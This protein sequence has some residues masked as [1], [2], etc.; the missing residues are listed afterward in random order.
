MLKIN[1]EPEWL[2]SI[3]QTALNSL[4]VNNDRVL[5]GSD[6]ILTAP[7]W[8]KISDSRI[9]EH[10]F[11]MLDRV[12]V[13]PK[14]EEIEDSNFSKF[15]P[16]SLAKPWEE[17]RE[18]LSAY[19]DHDDYDPGDLD[20]PKRSG[21][22]RTM[23]LRAVGRSLVK[24]SSAGLPYM[25]RK[26][27][28]L[29]TALSNYESEVDRYSCV[30][31]TRT[32]EGR[33]TRDVWGTPISDVIREQQYVIPYLRHE[34]LLAHRSAL[35]GPQSVDNSITNLLFGKRP[36]EVVVSVDFSG[37]DASIT[38]TMAHNA[39]SLIASDFQSSL[40]PGLYQI[41][42]RFVTIPIFTPEGEWSGP[43]GVPS[44]SAWTNTVDSAVQFLA[45]GKYAHRC[46]IQGDDGLYVVPEGERDELLR[47]FT[48][49]GLSINESKSHTFHSEEGIYLQRYYHPDYVDLYSGRG[50][51]GVYPI[52]RALNRIK[53]LERWTDLAREGMTGGDFFSLRTIMILE[54]C[55]HHPAFRD[56]VRY[57]AQTDAKGLHFTSEG[58]KAFS[59]AL[60]SKTRAG[61][62]TDR[63]SVV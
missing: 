58:L 14:L 56:L 41:Y 13:T 37:F 35:L 48:E 52:F 21:S 7:G 25:R 18:S 9:A 24:S 40:W 43:H 53:Y 55:K 44:G 8:D 63:K 38:P 54:N 3:S 19:F 1:A 32:Q 17:R 49:S 22:L 20:V 51:G 42:R 34:R 2:S 29:E 33:K 46:Q 27:L 26:G 47:R 45:A 12:H 62:L 30:L 36:S 31:Y 57:V 59:R 50:L 39:F 28:V 6:E 4:T 60:E 10:G 5:R 61:V 23:D 16:R 15:G 11:E